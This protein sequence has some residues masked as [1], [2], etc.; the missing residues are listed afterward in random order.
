VAKIW[1][2][3]LG[4]NGDSKGAQD[5][6]L[7]SLNTPSSVPAWISLDGNLKLVETPPSRPT[8]CNPEL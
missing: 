8:E 3:A 4:H 5:V 1:S 2:S 6:I 7:A